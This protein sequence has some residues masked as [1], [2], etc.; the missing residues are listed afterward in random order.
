MI[1]KKTDHSKI[2]KIAIFR[3]LQ[4]GDLLCSIPAVRALKYAFPN[5]AITLI[6]LPWAESFVERFS[7]YFSGF[8]HFPGYPGIEEQPFH[9]KQFISFL[10]KINK[11][12]FDLMIQMHG[13]G[14]I[15][16]PMIEMLGADRTAGYYESPAYCLDE[17]LCMPYPDNLSEIE[18]HLS[19]ME[20][21]GIP[22]QGNHLEFPISEKEQQEFIR[23]CKTHGLKSKKY[24]CVHPGARDK[25]RWWPANKFARVANTIYEKGYKIVLTGTEKERDIVNDLKRAMHYPVVNCVGET[26]LG[27]LAALIKNAKMLL[28]NDTGVSHIAAAVKTP[29][30]ILFL[31]SDPERWAPLNKKLHQIIWPHQSESIEHVL[32]KTGNV[33]RIKEP[34]ILKKIFNK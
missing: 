34:G 17:T 30:V 25:Q 16:N 3:A 24:V 23:L 32:L 33:L 7:N 31:S 18:K 29:S 4:I 8:I 11:E 27:A 28:S 21:L 6:G 2:K 9:L 22:S 1:M 19:L 20:F 26:S 5:A 10:T 13:N 15:L 12:Q 14:S